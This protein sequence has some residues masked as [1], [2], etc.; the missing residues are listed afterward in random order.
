MC[1]PVCLCVSLFLCEWCVLTPVCVFVCIPVHAH[2]CVCPCVCVHA[3]VC[4]CVNSSFLH[5]ATCVL[6]KA[7]IATLASPQEAVFL[8]LPLL[9]YLFPTNQL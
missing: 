4:P 1:V 6:T 2:V 3:A 9:I 8:L 7:C 5:E